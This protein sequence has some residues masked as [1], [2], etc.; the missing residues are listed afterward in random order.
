MQLAFHH[1]PYLYPT[2]FLLYPVINACTNKNKQGID[3]KILQFYTTWPFGFI[4]WSVFVINSVSPL[5][6]Y[7]QI[8]IYT[9]VYIYQYDHTCTCIYWGEHV[10]WTKCIL[11]YINKDGYLIN[12]VRAIV[13]NI[14]D[15]SGCPI[16]RNLCKP[17][18]RF[19]K[20]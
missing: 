5:H 2:I 6:M 17:K 12:D 20:R 16:R 13:A 1:Y 8:W 9:S 19:I 4:A 10:R 18:S 11:F 3:A 7:A 14:V 15:I